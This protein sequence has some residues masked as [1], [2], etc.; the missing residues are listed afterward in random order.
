MAVNAAVGQAE[1]SLAADSPITEDELL[2][3]IQDAGFF[4]RIFRVPDPNEDSDYARYFHATSNSSD[5][6]WVG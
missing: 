6:R 5:G 2:G 1:V 3:R 4:A